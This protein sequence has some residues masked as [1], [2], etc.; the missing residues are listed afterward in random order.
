MSP[1]VRQRLAF[2]FQGLYDFFREGWQD[3]GHFQ[4]WWEARCVCYEILLNLAPTPL[5]D[6]LITWLGFKLEGNIIAWKEEAAANK[7]P[8]DNIHYLTH[9]LQKG[10]N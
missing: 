7:T 4:N 6:E 9:Y 2:E 8:Y 5:R 1:Q 10:R 3:S